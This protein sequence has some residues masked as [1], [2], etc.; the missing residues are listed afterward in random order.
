MLTNL[1][2]FLHHV[3]QWID[4]NGKQTWEIIRF[5]VQQ[6]KASLR[7]N[8]HAHLVRDLETATSLKAFFGKKYLN[9]AKQFKA[10]APGKF[11]KKYG[12][13]LNQRQPFFRKRSRS[14]TPPPLVFQ[15]G[16]DHM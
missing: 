12:M 15:P 4:K 5:T 8:G 6:E 14:Q 10:V 2:V 16:K 1:M 9:V 11:V 3:C 7:R 13:T